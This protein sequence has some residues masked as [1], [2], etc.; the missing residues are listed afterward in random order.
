MTDNRYLRTY[1]DTVSASFSALISTALMPLT[2]NLVTLLNPE[3]D[4]RVIDLGCGPGAGIS[5]MLPL[6]QCAPIG[7]DFSRLMLQIANHR[8]VG[9]FVQADIERLSFRSQVFDGAL[10]S[11]S[12]NSTDPNASLREAYRV[13]RPGGCIVVQEWGEVDLLSRIVSETLSAYSVDNPP[14]AL[15]VM[16]DEMNRSTPWDEIDSVDSMLLCLETAGFS[17][18]PP[19]VVSESIEFAAVEDFLRYKF[20]WPSRQKELDAMQVEAKALCMADLRENLTVF[21]AGDNT[22]TW[23]PQIIRLIAHR[24]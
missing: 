18:A 5:L 15:A 3:K 2:K 8:A 7:V 19:L 13:L 10:A 12:L 21:A 23:R 20:A 11:F 24:Q 6:V 4:D 17:P 1:Y 16:R 22:L 14:A 9:T